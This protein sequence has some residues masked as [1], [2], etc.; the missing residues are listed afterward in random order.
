V[1]LAFA[2]VGRRP[3]FARAEA[4]RRR[5]FPHGKYR[6]LFAE[7]GHAPAETRAKIEKAFQQLFHGDALCERV[8]FDAGNALTRA[9]QGVPPSEEMLVKYRTPLLASRRASL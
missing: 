4:R 1:R 7:Q 8:Y 6:D 3:G 5:H 2:R 9:R